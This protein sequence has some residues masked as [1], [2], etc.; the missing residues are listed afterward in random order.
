MKP[1][2]ASFGKIPIIT[3]KTVASGGLVSV[4][5]TFRN[6]ST[7]EPPS[8][9]GVSHFIEHMVF[10]G[11][12]THSAE[13]IS[14]ETEKLGGYLNAFT[15][16]EQTSYYIS[17]F[18]EN[19]PEFLRILLDIVFNPL[20]RDEDFYH[21]QKVIL[22][23]IASLKDNPEEYLDEISESFLFNGHPLAMPIS[24]TAKEVSALSPGTLRDFYRS[25]YTPANCIISAAGDVTSGDII[26]ILEEKGIDPGTGEMNTLPAEAKYT[27]FMHSEK[28][29]S[30][31]LYAQYLYPAF[32]ATDGRRYA[33]GT[34][35]MILGGLMSS[36]LF[37]EIREK[38]GLCYNIESDV[39]LY[40][41]GGSISVFCGCEKESF[42]EVDELIRREIEKI[43]RNG[44][45][46]DEL[47]LA[48][49]QMLYSFFSGTETAGSRMFANI[50]HIFHYNRLVSRDEIREGIESVTLDD[51]NSLSEQ[52]F[53]D[54][55]SR[56]L[57]LPSE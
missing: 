33:L 38:R 13:E 21:E 24:G 34:L 42:D 46:V 26:S 23:E 9:N 39:G 22:T 1:E 32:P 35:N 29:S 8:I 56:C 7:S 47:T 6:G 20:M 53:A 49:N 30:E 31:H 44:I 50:R 55:G 12:P 40:S 57:L 17:G 45:T 41:T 14:R 18:S 4:C 48:R 16:K 43:S 5:I 37:Q 3:D 36:R 11:T 19:F 51:V 52:I 2:L 10:K 28:S 25:Y 15:T 27:A 54:G